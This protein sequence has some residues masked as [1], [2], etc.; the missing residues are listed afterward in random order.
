V[1]LAS[2]LV[3]GGGPAAGLDLERGRAKPGASFRP[4]REVGLL[5]GR[6]KPPQV[7]EIG[8]NYAEHADDRSAGYPDDPASFI[9]GGSHRYRPRCGRY[10]PE[11]TE[12]VTAG[13][14]LV[15]ETACAQVEH[16]WAQGEPA[17]PVRRGR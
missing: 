2:A 1:Q 14:G 13:T 9:K 16:D 8:L 10:R 3:D 6:G 12:R 4:A 7:W 5:A 17:N 15:F 11:R